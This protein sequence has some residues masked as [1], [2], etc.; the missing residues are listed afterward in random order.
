V[1]PFVLRPGEEREGRPR[2]LAEGEDKPLKYPALFHVA[3]VSSDQDRSA[4]APRLRRRDPRAK[5]PV[6]QPRSPGV[7]VS[8][9]TGQGWGNGWVTWRHGPGT[10]EGWGGSD[11]RAAGPIRG[12]WPACRE[13][14]NHPQ[15]IREI[16]PSLKSAETPGAQEEPDS[17]PRE[18]VPP[19]DPA[20]DLITAE[21]AAYVAASAVRSAARSECWWTAGRGRARGLRR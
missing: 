15:P 21:L 6:L 14:A 7:H 8:A 19:T 16:P 2:E 18:G 20:E 3:S 11:R 13:I 9:R 17:R 10:P 4:A 12:T 1:L 5:R